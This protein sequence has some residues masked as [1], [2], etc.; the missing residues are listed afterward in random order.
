MGMSKS[1]RILILLGIDSAFFLLEL[2]VG[3]LFCFI[4]RTPLITLVQGYGVRSLALVADAF[5]MVGP[6]A[7]LESLNSD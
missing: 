3:K 6:S 2:I 7:S 1:T 4:Q 5:H